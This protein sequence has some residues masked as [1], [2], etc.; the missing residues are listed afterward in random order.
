MRNLVCLLICCF[1]FNSHIHSYGW[2]SVYSNGNLKLRDLCVVNANTV[3]AVGF[4]TGSLSST[5]FLKTTNGG[6]SWVQNTLSGEPCY[7]TAKSNDTIYVVSGNTI[8]YKSTDGGANWSTSGLGSRG[9]PYFLNNNTGF[10]HGISNLIKTT[11]G[12]FTWDI[13][14]IYGMLFGFYFLNLNTGF[15][16]DAGNNKPFYKTTNGGNNWFIIS[17]L[18]VTGIPYSISFKDAQNGYIAGYTLSPPPNSYTYLTIAKTTNG[19][20]VWSVDVHDS[21]SGGGSDK[22]QFTDELTGYVTGFTKILKT[23]NGGAEWHYNYFAIEQISDMDFANNLTGYIIIGSYGRIL[24]TT[25]GGEPTKVE[26][27]NE[28]IPINYYLHQN[29]PNPFN[30]FTNIEFEI[31][32]KSNCSILAYNSQGQ[33]FSILSETELAPG[34]YKTGFDGSN[35]PS[36][37][38]FYQLFAGDYKETKKMVLLK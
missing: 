13:S 12:G 1:F 7:V 4:Y 18:P 27:Q 28:S 9:A 23:T 34:V 20:I 22:I 33:V 21:V 6:L 8:L 10:I 37:I 3:L 25:N 36:G 35:L 31:P 17:D 24:K 26:K 38:Y 11:N 16:A 14:G 15:I 30:P 29:Y 19:G 5:I 2:F 32:K